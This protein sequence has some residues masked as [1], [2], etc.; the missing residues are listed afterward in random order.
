MSIALI[1]INIVNLYRGEPIFDEYDSP[2]FFQFTFYPSFRMQIVTFIYSTFNNH[3]MIIVFQVLISTLSWIYLASRMLIQFDNKTINRMS[4]LFLYIL[5]TSTVIVEQNYILRSESLN[6]SALVFLIGA[7]LA[8]FQKSSYSNFVVLNISVLFLAGTRAVSSIS[9]FILYILF[10]LLMR[11]SIFVGSKYLVTTLLALVIN[12]FFIF[13]ATSTSISQVYTTSSIINERLWINSEWRQ[14]II[15]NG[16]PIQSRKIWENYREINKGLP[17]DQAVINSSEFQKWWTKNNDNFLFEFM[18]RNVDYS[19]VG[20]LCLPCL[21][22]NY[23]FRSTILSG[24]SQGTDEVRNN[25]N[26]Q[27][28]LSVR[29]FFWPE[30]TERA[31]IVV[32]SFVILIFL[33]HFIRILNSS[34]HDIRDIKFI[35]LIS[36]YI[37]SYS[38][39]SWW[40][41]SKENDMTRHQLNAAVGIRIILIYLFILLCNEL[42]RN[43]SKRRYLAK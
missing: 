43:Y 7:L 41:G 10:I 4:V 25:I 21:D 1:S 42:I 26:L 30:R 35:G 29:T 36:V 9:V 14:E 37:L 2:S 32:L 19:I 31:Y 17:P 15:D 22:G 20:P 39:I 23:S 28:L 34:L 6:N 8:Y 33:Y 38:Y 18:L 27:S 13:T 3:W 24:W 5:A 12:I 40:L 16:F 11:K